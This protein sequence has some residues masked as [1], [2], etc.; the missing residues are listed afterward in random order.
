MQF[1]KR[2]LI[3]LSLLL[4]GLLPQQT[5]AQSVELNKKLNEISEAYQIYFSYDVPALSGI[6]TDFQ[7]NKKQSY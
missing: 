3:T 7:V 5:A 4:I 1:L 2:P 6:Q